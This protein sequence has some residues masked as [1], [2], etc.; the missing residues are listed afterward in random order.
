VIV[1]GLQFTT[2]GYTIAGGNINT[3]TA[4]TPVQV[5]TGATATVSSIIAGTGGINNG[6]RLT[7]MRLIMATLQR[8]G[9]YA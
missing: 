2:T 1:T 4:S 6:S 7:G 5:D 9:R 3:T 8:H